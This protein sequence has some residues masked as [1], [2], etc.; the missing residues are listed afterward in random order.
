MGRVLSGRR[1]WPVGLPLDV[2]MNGV[3][4]SVAS[5]WADEDAGVILVNLEQAGD[6][7]AADDASKVEFQDLLARMRALLA[8]DTQALGILD[9]IATGSTRAEIQASLE[10]DGTAYDTGR[11]RMTR[12]LA[13]AFGPNW[14][15][16][17]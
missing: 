3:M 6:L 8:D 2:L 7:A 15:D 10:I 14:K 11:R 4:R 1:R 13:K 16:K 5:Q 9:G 12:L 17:V